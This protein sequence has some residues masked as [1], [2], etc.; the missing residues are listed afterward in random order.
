LPE[1]WRRAHVTKVLGQIAGA[2]GGVF[3]VP[4]EHRVAVLEGLEQAERG[5]S[6]TEQEM[7][8]LWKRCGVS[9]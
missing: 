1:D 6:M 8:T 2:G 9:S 3:V 4:A 7:A 5:E